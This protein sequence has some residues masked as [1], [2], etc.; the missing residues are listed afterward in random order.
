MLNVIHV[1][2]LVLILLFMPVIA[3]GQNSEQKDDMDLSIAESVFRFQ[4]KQCAAETTLRVFL[5]SLNGGDPSDDFMKRFADD[6]VRVRKKSDLVKSKETH[7]F[8]D[9]TSG[10]FAALLSIDKLK[11]FDEG[12]AE[13]DG[14]CGYADWA[15][16]GYRYTLIKQENRWIVKKADSKWFL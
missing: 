6:S 14:S 16:R 12:S 4:I 9:K 3:A 10:E 13:V 7:E 11:F 2:R 15:A 1:C 8:L 5:L